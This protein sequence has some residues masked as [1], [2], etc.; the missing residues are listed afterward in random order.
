MLGDIDTQFSLPH[1]ID[2]NWFSDKL[3]KILE[4]VEDAE[5]GNWI[6]FEKD[7]TTEKEVPDKNI[8]AKFIFSAVTALLG[9][10]PAIPDPKDITDGMKKLLQAYKYVNDGSKVVGASFGTKVGAEYIYKDQADTERIQ[11]H[12]VAVADFMRNRAMLF[13]SSRQSAENA[14]QNWIQEMWTA[15]ELPIQVKKNS[16]GA[17]DQVGF[18]KQLV[19]TMFDTVKP[20]SQA[21]RELVAE[22]FTSNG[23]GL[24]ITSDNTITGSWTWSIAGIPSSINTLLMKNL[25]GYVDGC[26][27]PSVNFKTAAGFPVQSAIQVRKPSSSSIRGIVYSHV[28]TGN[29]DVPVTAAD[30]KK[31]D[32]KTLCVAGGSPNFKKPPSQASQRFGSEVA[33]SRGFK[34]STVTA[35]GVG[36]LAGLWFG[37]MLIR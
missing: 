12:N 29:D 4:L 6:L 7:M 30:I 26:L 19:N 20:Q 31:Y 5:E 13:Q 10:L 35:G 28:Y 36:M 22:Y 3:I 25:L 1:G 8:W 27:Q 17:Q 24:V 11:D 9:S 2:E 23:I 32:S 18:L 21:Y 34:M 16:S 37:V 33:V 15:Y 14:L